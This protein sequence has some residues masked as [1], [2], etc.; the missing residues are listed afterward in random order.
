M[1]NKNKSILKCFHV[2]SPNDKQNEW[3]QRSNS[4]TQFNAWMDQMVLNIENVVIVLFATIKIAHCTYAQI[5]PLG[6]KKKLKPGG[7]VLGEQLKSFCRYILCDVLQLS[8][9]KMNKQWV[10]HSI[11]KR[12]HRNH[13]WWKMT[14]YDKNVFYKELTHRKKSIKIR[15]WRAEQ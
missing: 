8:E 4:N 11:L 6:Y 10:N 7:C 5:D 14:I 2:I 9:K 1:K 3:Q 15:N 12:N 13:F